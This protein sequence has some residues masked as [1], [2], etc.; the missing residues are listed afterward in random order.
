MEKLNFVEGVKK[1]YIIGAIQN[2]ASYYTSI[3]TIET[4]PNPRFGY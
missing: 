2:L 3:K 1:I 4:I